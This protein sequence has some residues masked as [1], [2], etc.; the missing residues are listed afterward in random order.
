MRIDVPEEAVLDAVLFDP[1]GAAAILHQLAITETAWIRP[2]LLDDISTKAGV[3]PQRFKRLLDALCAAGIANRLDDA[4]GL[5]VARDDALRHASVLRGAAYAL[6]RHRDANQ[7]EITLTPPAHPSRLME[8]LPKGAF[9]GL[10]CITPRTVLWS[11]PA[12]L[13]ADLSFL[14]RSLTVKGSTGS[15]ACS[16]QQGP[17]RW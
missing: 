1:Q 14:A 13:G 16:T 5:C 3:D 6:H 8:V 9:R 11:L 17:G 12:K 7:L 15:K 4:V 10:D 2:G